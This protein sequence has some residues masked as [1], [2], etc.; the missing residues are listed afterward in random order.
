MAPFEDS[1]STSLGVASR[2]V[3]TLLL[4][5]LTTC[6]VA[7]VAIGAA[8][9]RHQMRRSER[10]ARALRET[11]ERAFAEQARAHVTLESIADAVICTDR[12]QRVSYL[13]DAAEH[14]TLWPEVEARDSCCRTCWSCG[15]KS[16]PTAPRRPT[17]RVF[18]M[19]INAPDPPPACCSR[20]ATDR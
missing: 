15:R 12:D 10:M 5:V 8:L 13:N 4:I 19:A 9:S 6:G 14:L 17:S 1:F 18:S 11:E 20:V 3:Q 7:L 16:A 2:E